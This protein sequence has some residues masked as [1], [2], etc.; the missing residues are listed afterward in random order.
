VRTIGPSNARMWIP[1]SVPSVIPFFFPFTGHTSFVSVD[2]M[3]SE[4]C[5]AYGCLTDGGGAA[6]R[7]S[8]TTSVAFFRTFGRGSSVKW[9]IEANDCRRPCADSSWDRSSAT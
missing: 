4:T 2:R 8:R 7:T 5:D 1:V 3:K 6:A 9:R